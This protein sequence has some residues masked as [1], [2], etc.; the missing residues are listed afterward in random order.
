MSECNVALEETLKTA[1]RYVDIDLAYETVGVKSDKK[2]YKTEIHD[3]KAIVYYSERH[4]FFKAIAE[5]ATG[6]QN[7]C[8]KLPFD[9]FGVMLDC[10]RNGVPSIESLKAFIVRLAFAG[11]NYLGL[12]LEDC[13]EVDNEPF[14]G[15]MRGR[16]S[17]SEM[18]QLAEFADEFGIELIPYIQ[19]LAHLN[20]IFHHW[21]EYANTVKDYGDILLVDEPR[22]YTLI[23]NMLKTL[24]ETFTTKRVNIGMDEAFM[25]LFG[26]YRDLH[27]IRDRAEVFSRHINKVCKL[28]DK[29]GLKPAAWADMFENYADSDK[30]ELPEN[31]TLV[32]WCYH[33]DNEKAYIEK[34]ENLKTITDKASFAGAVHKWYGYAPLN[35]FSEKTALPAV[36]AAENRVDDFC[37]TAWGDDGSECSFNAIWSTVLK[38]AGVA[39]RSDLNAVEKSAELLTGYSLSDLLATD[40]P[41][42][43]F[44]KKAEKPINVS[45]YTLFEDVFYGISDRRSSAAWVPYFKKNAEK[46]KNIAE[47]GGNFKYIYE[48]YAA[49][50]EVLALK[51]GYRDKLIDA[52]KEKNKQKL[53]E[54]CDEL[55]EII[56][57]IEMFSA[58]VE[59]QWEKD[60]KFFGSEI[61]QIRLGGLK[62]R[63]RYCLKRITDYVVGKTE[64]I[65][66]LDEKDLSPVL[67]GDHYNDAMCFNNYE[68]NVTYCSL[69][70]KLFN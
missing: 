29:Y 57:K 34:I 15:Y 53:V 47:K 50:C 64:N 17:H 45:K 4:Y 51:T 32:G 61:Q 37:L 24:S 28:C 49:L 44:N 7:A 18:K 67:T 26:K 1:K 3:G 59:I 27:G 38:V 6:T 20:S 31:L 33:L 40:L 23:E 48:E 39:Y 5:L 52:Y 42:K 69:S 70:V 8:G 41:N 55:R 2:G 63:L 12:Y 13:F 66:E 9:R 10:A 30:L 11:Y 58:K 21:E 68:Q 46:L 54:L 62:E 36:K 43:I 14:F 25:M 19:T 22:T 16:Y 60:Y 65:P 35:E 56:F